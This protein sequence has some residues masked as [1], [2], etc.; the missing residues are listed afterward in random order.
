MSGKRSRVAK[1]IEEEEPKAIYTYYF[2]HALNLAAGDTTKACTTLKNAL[3]ITLEITKLMKLSP[4]RYAIF[5][6]LKEQLECSAPGIRILCPTRWTVPVDSLKNV[7]GNYVVLR[8]LCK[9]HLKLF[10]TPK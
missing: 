4:R 2:G 6:R 3:D 10:L 9:R 5:L 1:Q 7:F 8:E